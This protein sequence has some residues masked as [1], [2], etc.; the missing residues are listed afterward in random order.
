MMVRAETSVRGGD[1]IPSPE[2]SR[3]QFHAQ[4]STHD[5]VLDYE[6]K[7]SVSDNFEHVNI[8][9]WRYKRSELVR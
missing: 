5:Y 9:L 8:Q 1:Q 6:D 3:T 2:R 7:H 4:T